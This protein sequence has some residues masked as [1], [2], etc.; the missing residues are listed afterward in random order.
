MPGGQQIGLL[1]VVIKGLVT[2]GVVLEAAIAALRRD[3]RLAL[4]ACAFEQGVL[5]QLELILPPVHL[6]IDQLPGLLS[7]LFQY[8]AQIVQIGLQ[9]RLRRA[10]C[11][12]LGHVQQLVVIVGQ[13]LEQRAVR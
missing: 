8:L 11:L 4:L 10:L 13:G 7:A 9:Q 6:G 3:H 12:C 1:E 5:H 2:P